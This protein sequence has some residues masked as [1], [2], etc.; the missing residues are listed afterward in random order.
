[1]F[2]FIQVSVAVELE[3]NSLYIV[4]VPSA[5]I[6]DMEEVV[7]ERLYNASRSAPATAQVSTFKEVFSGEQYI[8]TF[9]EVGQ[10]AFAS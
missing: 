2:F 10:F 8:V 5:K 1:M 3:G 9:R 6:F 4:K 7:N